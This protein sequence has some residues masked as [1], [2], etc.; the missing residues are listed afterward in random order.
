MKRTM[1]LAS[2]SKRFAAGCIDLAFPLVAYII[3][4]S[5]TGV[6]PMSSN[7]DYRAASNLTP[8]G[9][10]AILILSVLLL[11]FLVVQFVFYARAQS[12]GKAIIGLQVVS[13][14]DGSPMTFWRMLFREIIV[15]YASQ[16]LLLGYI[17]ILIDEKNRGWHDKILDT[18][19]V[20]IRETAQLAYREVE[21][22]E[23][24]QIHK[25]DITP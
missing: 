8:G 6:S 19:V 9:A 10:I 15:K 2:R 1:K 18:Y 21:E 12:I 22:T 11:A 25:K 23:T 3:L 16:V 13:S 24:E 7:Y 17:W 5:L 14:K 20:D 4:V